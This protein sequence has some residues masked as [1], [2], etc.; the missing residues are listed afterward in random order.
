MTES[1]ARKRLAI[2][3]SEVVKRLKASAGRMV[4]LSVTLSLEEDEE[5]YYIRVFEDV[6][7]IMAAYVLELGDAQRGRG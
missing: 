2:D 4:A 6:T 1:E 7:N 5:A 3:A